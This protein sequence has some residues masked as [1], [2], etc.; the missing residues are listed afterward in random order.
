MIIASEERAV[1]DIA[2]E[3]GKAVALNTSSIAHYLRYKDLHFGSTFY[4]GI[5]E[6]PPGSTLD[7][8]FK[9][10]QLLENRSWEDYYY[11]KPFYKEELR[12]NPA[13]E[14]SSVS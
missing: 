1:R 9:N 11:S 7:F 5:S 12:D 14:D 10:W 3:Y 6:L 13:S 2:R 8:D 4:D